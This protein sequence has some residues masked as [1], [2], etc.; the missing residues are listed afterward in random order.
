VS[1]ADIQ[2]LLDGVGAELG[3][4]LA[5]TDAE[6]RSVAHSAHAD[7]IDSVREFGIIHR[8]TPPEVFSWFEQWG[9]RSAAGPVRTPPDA[10][11][12]ILARW[13]IPVRFR[14]RLLGYL[15][16]LDARSIDESELESAVTAAE[17]IAAIMYRRHLSSA[18][19]T[20]LLRVLLIP[21]PESGVVAAEVR[22]L[23]NLEQVGHIQVIVA[24]PATADEPWS[25][26]LTSDLAVAIQR[27]CDANAS[28]RPTLGGIV[29]GLGVLLAPLRDG[30][31]TST[32]RRLAE[33]I[34]EVAHRLNE[35]LSL[36]LAIGGIAD[37]DNASRS[38]AEA[39]RALKMAR[40]MPNLG[41]ITAWDTLGVFRVIAHLPESEV[42]EGVIDR[43]VRRL[44]ADNGLATTAETFLDLA[45][46]VQETAAKLFLHRTTLYQRLD[47][48]SELY[49]LDLRRN[50][51]HRLIAHIG[52]KLARATS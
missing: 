16:I 51:D 13:C 40:A 9:I 34:R 20:D 46:N 26:S 49:G 52:L 8:R 39:C 43:R 44:V 38:Y 23:G 37:L 31:D 6:D 42:E 5:L 30:E 41:P 32:A 29:S 36:V 48:I 24:G 10:E 28:A 12:G 11:Q 2:A 17:Q 21:N 15:W 47:R 22:T 19:D 1:E 25:A 7:A 18:I 27:A 3:A 50:G 4:G 14:G 45:G 35:R 33:R